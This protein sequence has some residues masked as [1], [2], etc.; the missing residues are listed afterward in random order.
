M[1]EEAKTDGHSI[2]VCHVLNAID[3]S[4]AEAEWAVR[5]SKR[6]DVEE[7][8]VLTWFWDEDFAGRDTIDVECL[9]IPSG[10]LRLPREK[11]GT[12]RRILERHDVVHTHHNHSAFYAKLVGWR[13]GKVIVNT[14]HNTHDGFTRKGRLANGLTNALADDVVCVSNTVQSSF[15]KWERLLVPEDR[16][17][18]IYNGVDADRLRAGRNL[19]W[20]VREAAGLD[21]ETLLVGTAGMLDEQK[22]HDVLVDAVAIANERS[23]DPIDLVVSGDGPLHDDLDARIRASGYADRMHLL[24]FLETRE[25]VYRMMDELDIYAMPSRWE[26]F[27]I[28][29]MEAMWLG[30]PCVL[31][32]LPVFRE[33]YDGRARYHAVDDAE[34]LASELVALANDATEREGLGD[35][36]EEFARSFTIAETVSGYLEAYREH[37]ASED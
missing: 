17:R 16:V 10:T 19:D 30:T 28:A 15:Q 37:L 5:Q 9:D 3:E 20:S 8:T 1:S 26:G 12:L 14:E 36:A 6:E 35:R 25:H 23:D 31:S 7:V 4:S 2:S 21:P 13:L 29:V 18:V 33:L 11:Y 24:G 34:A 32:D 27:C 22:A